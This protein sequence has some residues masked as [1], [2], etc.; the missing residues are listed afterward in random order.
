MT[1]IGGV[2]TM[3]AET[4]ITWERLVQLQ[5]RLIDL[6][7]RALAADTSNENCWLDVWFGRDSGYGLKGEMSKLVGW[8]AP[9]NAP[10][11]LTTDIAYEVAYN[12]ILSAIPQCRNCHCDE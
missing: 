3:E 1:Y 12:H 11:E 8:D 10:S 6:Y 5:P 2:A 4:R 7:R 9:R